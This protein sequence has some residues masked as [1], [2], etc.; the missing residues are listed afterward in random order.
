MQPKPGVEQLSTRGRAVSRFPSIL[1]SVASSSSEGTWLIENRVQGPG[2]NKR[3]E[4]RS[5]FRVTF[6][7]FMHA[8]TLPPL[9]PC[10][11]PSAFVLA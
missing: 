7:A 4:T 3:C 6:H 8:F 5:A 2:E 10:R 9:S 11:L 1:V